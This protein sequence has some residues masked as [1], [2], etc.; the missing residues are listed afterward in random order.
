MRVEGVVD[1]AART[2]REG[3]TQLGTARS[4]GGA[5]GFALLGGR[6]V[7]LLQVLAD[8]LAFWPH[9]RIE[10]KRLEGQVQLHLTG[11]ALGGLLERAQPDDA[12]GAGHIGNEINFEGGGHHN[13]RQSGKPAF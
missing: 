10:L 5:R 1:A 13:L 4:N 3:E 9:L 2:G 11:Q 6:A 12:P 8:V 7:F